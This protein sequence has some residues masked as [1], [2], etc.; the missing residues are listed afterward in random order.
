MVNQ[1]EMINNAKSYLTEDKNTLLE[2]YLYFS[3][4]IILLVCLFNS[5]VSKYIDERESKNEFLL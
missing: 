5:L 3:Y 4:L 1:D 2:L